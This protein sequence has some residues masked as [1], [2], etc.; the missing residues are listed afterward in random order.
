MSDD[1]HP[2][3]TAATAPLHDTSWFYRARYTP[4]RDAMRG[5]LSARLDARRVIANAKLPKPLADVTWRVIR[6]T[7]LW[8]SEKVAVAEELTSHFLDGLAAGT[9]AD[10]LLAAFGDPRVA[11]TLIRRAKKRARSWTWKSLKGVQYGIVA[12][13]VLYVLLWVRLL[14]REPSL[15]ET[16][17]TDAAWAKIDA[18]PD[19]EVAWPEF[20]RIF[21][22]HKLTHVLI[23]LFRQLIDEQGRVAPNDTT[24]HEVQAYLDSHQHVM[25]ELRHATRYPYDHKP[26]RDT[27]FTD[28][29]F[30]A[31]GVT[32]SSGKDIRYFANPQTTTAMFL[33]ADLI[34]AVEHRDR[35]RVMKDV[36][37]IIA[38]SQ[39]T[40]DR[41]GRWMGTTAS[42]IAG[43]L[44]VQLD[45]LLQSDA[46]SD[47]LTDD[48]LKTI[49]HLVAANASLYDIQLDSARTWSDIQ[50]ARYYDAGGGMTLEGIERTYDRQRQFRWLNR[51][52][53]SRPVLKSLFTMLSPPII[54]LFTDDRETA[55]L[56]VA[57]EFARIQT[58]AAS[59]LWELPVSNDYES[60]RTEITQTTLG[61]LRHGYLL[62][63]TPPVHLREIKVQQAQQEATLVGLALELYRREHDR[64]PN[65]LAELSPMYLPNPPTDHSTGKPLLFKIGATGKPVI[66]GRGRDGDDDGG[67]QSFSTT[68]SREPSKD[69]D[70]V[71]VPMDLPAGR[72]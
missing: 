4:L 66:Y 46:G 13:L 52:Q 39:Q 19:E 16:K 2:S 38:L 30:A 65:S 26:S 17:Y 53:P 11:A 43:T 49:A 31:F 18:I 72:Y 57:A 25:D 34:A 63:M 48:D 45:T 69:G 12:M 60:T 51:N 20:R 67:V 37:A 36:K 21:V 56:Y 8:R 54:A 33:R 22:E 41:T 28:E 55:E 70:W 50:L 1:N 35:D 32:D 44:Y 10:E 3:S 58:A 6:G 15:N 42:G 71:L 61:A 14:M 23:P 47:F 68:R 29:D 59:P 27:G 24:W 5:H 40:D 9:T 7:R 64:Y 62:A